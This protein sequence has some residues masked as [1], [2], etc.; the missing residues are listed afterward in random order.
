MTIYHNIK[1]E[2]RLRDMYLG[3]EAGVCLPPQFLPLPI[4]EI[5]VKTTQNNP[6]FC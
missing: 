2:N 5:S 4:E 6:A 3:V 1:E